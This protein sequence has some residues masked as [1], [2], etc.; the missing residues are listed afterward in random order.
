MTCP[1]TTT[2]TTL[3]S[4]PLTLRL[5]GRGVRSD[6]CSVFTPVKSWSRSRLASLA[7]AVSSALRA[8]AGLVSGRIEAALPA[9]LVVPATL[10]AP[11]LELESTRH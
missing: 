5:C 4:F 6:A 7:S 10:P 11:C 9:A 2:T 1:M 3:L 8:D